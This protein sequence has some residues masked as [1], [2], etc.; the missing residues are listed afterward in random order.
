MIT[1]TSELVKGF[2]FG[3]RRRAN[4]EITDAHLFIRMVVTIAVKSIPK[5][6]LNSAFA[7]AIE[8]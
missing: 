7:M 6:L 4:Q 8:G 2:R 1:H 3:R 5:Y